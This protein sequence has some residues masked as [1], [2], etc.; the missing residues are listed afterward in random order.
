MEY[1]IATERLADHHGSTG[2]CDYSKV[3]YD[4]EDADY[5]YVVEHQA[6]YPCCTSCCA[7]CQQ[8]LIEDED[9]YWSDNDTDTDEDEQ[10]A[11]LEMSAPELQQSFERC[12]RRYIRELGRR[13]LWAKRRFR[14]SEDGYDSVWNEWEELLLS[15]W[16]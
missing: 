4:C 5:S 3:H 6:G 8:Y 2:T 14:Q 15:T 12:D 11:I 1:G 9:E 10:Q 16:T 7:S 13:V